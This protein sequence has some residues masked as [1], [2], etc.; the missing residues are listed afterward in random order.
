MLYTISEYYPNKAILRIV[1]EKYYTFQNI[2]FIVSI[3]NVAVLSFYTYF[4][5]NTCPGAMPIYR[6]V[7]IFMRLVSV[8]FRA[9]YLKPCRGGLK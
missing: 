4:M 1:A 9:I 8:T 6:L 7:R 2:Q 3:A 5:L